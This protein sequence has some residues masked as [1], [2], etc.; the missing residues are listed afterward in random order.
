[1]VCLVIAVFTDFILPSFAGKVVA[2]MAEGKFEEIK[3]WC[4]I[5]FILC[6]VSSL[7]YNTIIRFLAALVVSEATSSGRLLRCSGSRSGMTFTTRSSIRT[8]HSST[9]TGLVTSV[10]E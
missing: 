8:S 2:L 10:S 5:T 9:T 6:S 7:F 4:W 3:T 1:M